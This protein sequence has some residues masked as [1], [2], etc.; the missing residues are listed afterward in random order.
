MVNIASE[1]EVNM[2]PETDVRRF[3]SKLSTRPILDE[4]GMWMRQSQPLMHCYRVCRFDFRAQGW[5]RGRI[6]R[7]GQ[8]HG[9]EAAFVRY[10]RQVLCWMDCWLG[11]KIGDVDGLGA[12]VAGNR[13][14]AG[15]GEAGVGGGG[16]EGARECSAGL[17]FACSDET[18]PFFA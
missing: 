6:E 5:P 7:W 15:V 3:R 13:R 14:A 16:N 9:V 10:N 4:A 18:N 11:L 2:T 1:R 8:R 17:A 12:A